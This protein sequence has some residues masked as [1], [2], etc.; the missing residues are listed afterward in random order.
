MP[1]FFLTRHTGSLP[2]LWLPP[3]FFNTREMKKDTPLRPNC[4]FSFRT[5]D[6]LN[7]FFLLTPLSFFFCK[8]AILL[9]L[10]HLRLSCRFAEAPPT[11]SLVGEATSTLS[12]SGLNFSSTWTAGC[13]PIRTRPQPFF[14]SNPFGDDEVDFYPLFGPRSIFQTPFFSHE[15]RSPPFS[16]I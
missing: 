6:F 7:L 11:F 14:T 2:F 10:G 13:P 3:L 5:H 16:P 15:C 1:S 9:I 12:L 8:M 4:P